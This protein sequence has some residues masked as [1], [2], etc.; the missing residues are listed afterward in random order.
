MKTTDIYRGTQYTGQS[1][2]DL[3]RYGSMAPW[4]T[5][6]VMYVTDSLRNPVVGYS[7]VVGDKISGIVRECTLKYFAKWAQKIVLHE[8]VNLTE[9]SKS[10]RHVISAND[11]E[12]R[13]GTMTTSISITQPKKSPNPKIDW[14][15][16]RVGQVF[17]CGSSTYLACGQGESDEDDNGYTNGYF[18][19]FLLDLETMDVLTSK[20]EITALNLKRV[21]ANIT[22]ELQEIS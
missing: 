11:F 6:S 5:R 10:D 13:D 22:V 8:D 15:G 17:T 21:P 19:E 14:G 3:A 1:P 4:S 7:T 12:S 20:D 16:A 2:Q 18:A 9:T